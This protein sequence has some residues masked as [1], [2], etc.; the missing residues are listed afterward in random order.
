M[1]EVEPHQ[2]GQVPKFET[3]LGEEVHTR[4]LLEMKTV[5]ESGDVPAFLDATAK[6][7]L[8]QGRD[9]YR[10]GDL[11]HKSVLEMGG[12]VLLF[13]WVGTSS[14][15]AISVALAGMGVRSEDN[16]VG[17]TAL[18]SRDKVLDAL[19]RLASST[20]EDMA[21]IENGAFGLCT[22]KYDEFIGK[23][24]LRRFWGRRNAEVIATIPDVAR[25]LLNARP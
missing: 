24:L 5:Y 25:R 9:A 12:S 2:G 11:A 14:V 8:A 4:L 20:P 17:L 10:R 7:L 18:A 16:G 22:A 23:E 19:S 1:I 6:D 3:P 21:G 15:A 13:P